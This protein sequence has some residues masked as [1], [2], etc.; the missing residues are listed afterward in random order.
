MIF[1]STVI[2]CTLYWTWLSG[3]PDTL[4]DMVTVLKFVKK[5]NDCTVDIVIVTDGR[6]LKELWTIIL[7]VTVLVRP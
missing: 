5:N 1:S 6:V 2:L 4:A 3:V 7:Y